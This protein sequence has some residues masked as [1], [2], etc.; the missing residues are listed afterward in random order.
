M[1]LLIG[2]NLTVSSLNKIF[3]P[4]ESGV[5]NGHAINI[6]KDNNGRSVFFDPHVNGY[7]NAQEN[8]NCDFWNCPELN[9]IEDLCKHQFKKGIL[10]FYP[11]LITSSL[12]DFD[13]NLSKI[14]EF[15]DKKN[16][17]S[18]AEAHQRGLSYIRGVHIEGG[19]IS[20]KGVHPEKFTKVFQDINTVKALVEKYPGLI[21]MWTLCPTLDPDGKI[22]QYLQSQGIL[23]S[24][25]H[26]KATYTQA[27]EAFEKHGV[28]TV[29]H[30]G[31]TMFLHKDIPNARDITD[32]QI[33]FILDPKSIDKAENKDDFGIGYYALHNPDITLQMICGSEEAKDLHINPKLFAGAYKLKGPEKFALVSDVACNPVR[34]DVLRGAN[35]LVSEHHENFRKLL[36]NP[37]KKI[38]WLESI[39]NK[40]KRVIFK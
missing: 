5:A 9:Q 36:E 22:T 6:K 12:Q 11:T 29:T 4:V 14:K 18:E 27:K 21:K 32:E 10:A 16:Y 40:F 8:V 19:L 37:E 34:Q 38:S 13:K 17:K 35:E 25:G 24:Y 23:V 1:L 33:K 30:W 20:Q 3:S 39:Y 15:I 7:Y 26:S 31:N 28:N 2:L